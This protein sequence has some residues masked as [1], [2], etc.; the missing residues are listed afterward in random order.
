MTETG[1]SDWDQ[2]APEVLADQIAAY[3]RMRRQCPVAYDVSGNWAVFR[4][5]DVV[6]VLDE[7]HTFS[8]VV[9][10]HVAVPNGMDPPQHTAFRAIVDRYFT[11]DRMIALE[12]V[13]RAIAAEMIDGLPR[14]E[15][16]EAMAALAEPYASRAQCGFMGWPEALHE[17]MQRWTKDN[18]AATHAQD[19]EAMSAVASAFDGHIREQ[20]EARR[21]AGSDAPDDPTTE[22]LSDQVDGRAITDAEIVSI[23]RNWTVGELATIA[24][25]VGIIL[26]YLA[27][28]PDVQQRLRADV[29]L[30][31]RA[32]DEILR[33]RAPL[34]ANRRR[35]TRTAGLGARTIPAREPVMVVWASANR[36]EEVFGDPDLFD[37]DRDLRLNLLY[38]RGIHVCPGAPL[39]RLELR[40]IVEQL[41]ADTTDIGPAA[42]ACA[43]NAV[44]PASGFATLPLRFA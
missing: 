24:A 8:N 11:A 37:L 12:P 14:G 17:R 31:E 33:M 21:A 29:S 35:T 19:R 36:D 13:V 16:V 20:L 28:H 1:E 22:L 34:V 43:T 27:T 44:Y 25:S 40:V 18:H 23:V 7:H 4:H 38:G 2:Y 32:T 26:H 9:S 39:A 30:I 42:D 3:D 10:R 5:A 6:R 15:D 41:F